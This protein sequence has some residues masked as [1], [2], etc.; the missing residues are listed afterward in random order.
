[1]I[2]E[3]IMTLGI[4]VIFTETPAVDCGN[5]LSNGCYE[6]GT[7][8]IYLK[9]ENDNLD[10]TF[11]HELGHAIFVEDDYSRTIIKDYPPLVNY[12]TEKKIE[13]YPSFTKYGNCEPHYDT[14]ENRLNERVANYFVEYI[15]NPNKFS[16]YN[17]VLYIYFR[18]KL[19]NIK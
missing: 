8:T 1:M 13:N 19:N 2:L 3:I 15:Y 18:D 9:Y 5:E 4:S 17:P 14:E 11:Y 6:T 7:N 12:C 16:V 10:R